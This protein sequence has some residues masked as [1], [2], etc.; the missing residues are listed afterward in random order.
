LSAGALLA[1]AG[2]G[3]GGGGPPTGPTP[4]DALAVTVDGSGYAGFRTVLEC[5]VVDRDPCVTVLEA[6]RADD[7]ARCDALPADDSRIGVRGVIDG[8]PIAVEL[9]RRTTCEA[10][11]HDAVLAALGL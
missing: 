4:P 3:G 8:E 9:R 7:A 2:C 10:A 6:I 5:V 1:A 11:R